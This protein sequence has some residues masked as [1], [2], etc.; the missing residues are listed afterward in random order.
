MHTQTQPILCEISP[1]KYP[2]EIPPSKANKY[3]IK[4][5]SMEW[6]ITHI[7]LAASTLRD[8][9]NCGKKEGYEEEL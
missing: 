3:D 1:I 8:A 4:S 7:H 5:E 6:D 9:Q 2:Y